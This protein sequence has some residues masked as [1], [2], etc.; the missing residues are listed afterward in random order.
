[1]AI[2]FSRTLARRSLFSVFAALP[3]LVGAR[4]PSAQPRPP[5][6][7]GPST[8]VAL[9]EVW[10]A[11]VPYYDFAHSTLGLQSGQALQLRRQP[12]NRFDTA[13]IEI[14]TADGSAKLGYVPRVLNP[15][16]A[17]MMDSGEVLEACIAAIGT[18]HAH[19]AVVRIEW[20]RS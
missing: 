1:M 8:R 20:S 18:N 3:L 16:L 10:I 19:D 2:D 14:L 5:A 13:A 4:S 9:T 11:G 17:A 12:N 15:P 6:R 7:P